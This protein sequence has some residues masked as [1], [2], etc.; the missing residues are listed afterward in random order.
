MYSTVGTIMD[1]GKVVIE[2]LWVYESTTKKKQCL[3]KN[4]ERRID[5]TSCREG[6]FK[7][8][9]LVLYIPTSL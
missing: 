4:D 3:C 8:N 5:D 6:G 1:F 9:A 7:C 2:C